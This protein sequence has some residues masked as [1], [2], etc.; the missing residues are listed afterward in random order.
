MKKLKMEI[1]EKTA[2]CADLIEWLWMR[3]LEFKQLVDE[4]DNEKTSTDK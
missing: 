2:T 3:E 4:W 1:R